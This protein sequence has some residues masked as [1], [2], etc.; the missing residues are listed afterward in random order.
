MVKRRSWL[1]YEEYI[2][3][4]VKPVRVWGYSR[5]GRYVCRAEINAAGIAI[6]AGK[7]GGKK[8]ADVSW[9]KLVKRLQTK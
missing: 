6:Y 4:G 8:L 2:E 1:R 7:K 9:E 5:T 3:L